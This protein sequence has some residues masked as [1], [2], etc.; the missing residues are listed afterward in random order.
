MKINRKSLTYL[1]FN[2]VILLIIIGVFFGM[3]IFKNSKIN[4]TIN[5][6]LTDGNGKKAKVVL[7]A[8]QSN[9]SGC[10]SDAYLKMNIDE[11]KY[12]EYQEGYDNIYINYYAT[13]TNVSNE[14]V[15][16]ASKQG[17]A[18][19]F[20]GPELGIADKLNE[21]YPDETF[22]IIKYAYGGSALY[23]KWRSP[24]FFNQAG[25][26]YREFIKFVETSMD[27]LI[28][29]NYDVEIIGMCWMQGESDSVNSKVAKNYEKYLKRFIKDI[30]K[31]FKKYSADAGIA[32]ID[33]YIADNEKYWIY[34]EIIN[35]AKQNI[36]DSSKLNVVIDT[37]SYG[38]TCLYEPTNEP[39]LAHYDSLSQIKLGHL[40]ALEIA[41][42]IK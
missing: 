3:N 42:F 28:S 11:E 22:F 26:L 16:C 35:N 5:D 25:N 14:F 7:L 27:Y 10:S 13:G 24:S 2:F 32:F 8:G 19:G 31:D 29:K 36:A 33:A 18:G 12:K 39:D 4:F 38:L 20:F 37:I 15:K 17:E 34:Y 9:A 40:F 6:T 21:L 23:D 30:R 1:L 41:N